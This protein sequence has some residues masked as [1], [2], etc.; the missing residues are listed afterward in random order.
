MRI[1]TG[2]VMIGANAFL[3]QYIAP[4]SLLFVGPLIHY[5]L[6]A[7]EAAADPL[8]SQFGKQA[9]CHSGCGGGGGCGVIVSAVVG[10]VW[11]V[12]GCG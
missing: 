4:L 3:Q 11:W 6:W 12:V 2:L 5:N 10:G 8:R 1:L 9:I 7:T